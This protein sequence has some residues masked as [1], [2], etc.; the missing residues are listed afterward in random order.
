MITRIN[1]LM[2]NTKIAEV[3]S[4]CESTINAISSVIYNGVTSTARREI[5]NFSIENLF[6]GLSKYKNDEVIN[7]W[8]T[9]EKRLFAIKN[10]GVRKAINALQESDVKDHDTIASILEDYKEKLEFYPEVTLYEGFISALSGFNYLPAVKTELNAMS[11]RVKTYKNDIDITKILEAMKQTKSNYLLP[12]IETYVND[13]LTNKT[14]QTKHM[15]KE[16]LIKFSYDPFVRDL[17]NIISLDATELQLEYA[18][19]NCGITEKLYSPIIYLGESETLF[20]I[21]GTYYIRKGNNINKLASSELSKLDPAFTSLCEIVNDSRVV[22]GKKDIEVYIGKDTAVINESGIAVNGKAISDINNVHELARMTGNIEIYELSE[23]LKNNFDEIVEIDFCKRVFL[24][25]NENVAADVFKLRDNIFITTFDPINNK[26]TFYRNINPIQAE[27]VMMEHLRYDV[28]NAFKD[29]LPNKSRILDQIRET[30]KEYVTY[31]QELESKI[32][33]Y[34]EL[35]ND[36]SKNVVKALTEEL[37][38]VKA[39]YIDYNNEIE[40]Y[41]RPLDEDLT[42]TIQ[43]DQTN[44]THTVTV[45][46]DQLSS[47]QAAKGEGEDEAGTT[48]GDENI[49]NGPASQITFNDD[50]SE[51]LTD[52]PTMPT[53]S[54]DMG[55]E[56]V[57]ADAAEKEAEDKAKAKDKTSEESPIE[58]EESEENADTVEAPIEDETSIKTPED[59]EKEKDEEDELNDSVETPNLKRTTFD[60]DKIKEDEE[61]KPTKRI[62]LKK[63]VAAK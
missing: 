58:G 3:K 44:Q 13:Y 54:V 42:I 59:E 33:Q 10:L 39:D 19:G 32:E 38:E 48:V 20:N 37:D 55:A 40:K 11:D 56:D 53:D 21:K 31:I 14:E 8:L 35:N 52:E 28:S 2:S 63:K 24:N 45:P 9:T 34:S 50:E 29:I 43:D 60:K 61:S 47:D 49:S 46:T 15:L 57:E 36:T 23:N 62:F 25:E 5:E 16:A 1:Q 41:T 22:I 17:I 7:K 51:L 27:K 30:K 4:L 6:E 26:N 12:L 18:S